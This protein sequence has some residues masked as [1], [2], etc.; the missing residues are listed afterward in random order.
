MSRWWL[1]LWLVAG[2]QPDATI[3]LLP[4][5][6]TSSSGQGGAGA[7][8]GEPHGGAPAGGASATTGG[9]GGTGGQHACTSNA[10]CPSPTPMCDPAS[11]ACIACP[12]GLLDCDGECVD[13][14]A[15]PANCGGCN[16]P[17]GHNQL[18]HDGTC[19]CLPG[20][21][22]CGDG[23]CHHLASDPDHCGQSCLDAV[24]CAAGH[25]CDGGVCGEGECSPGL[26]DCLHPG[27]RIACI[28]LAVGY[29]RC[30]I[31]DVSCSGTEVC[32]GGHCLPYQP[33]AP[34][35]ACPCE[36]ECHAALGEASCCSVY[37]SAQP[38]CVDG[39]SCP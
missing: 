33:A 30:G 38:M 20:T 36:G 7:T 18:C 12:S 21:E 4:D 10:E 37:G 15:D 3:D 2:C 28:D 22:D 23:E 13:T 8:G 39:A 1:C 35:I 26:A 9:S 16:E 24:V 29:P 27:D 34:C 5:A 32:V 11:G 25:K 19:T 31:C 6:G 17:C 14:H